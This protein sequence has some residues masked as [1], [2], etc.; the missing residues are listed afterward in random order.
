MKE[1]E[2]GGRMGSRRIEEKEEGII[3][4][5]RGRRRRGKDEY[6]GDEL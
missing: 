4:V 5:R 2:D 3:M 6:E 1:K